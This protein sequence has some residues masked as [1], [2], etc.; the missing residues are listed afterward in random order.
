MIVPP[1]N[2]TSG[3]S[4]PALIAQP[5]ADLQP[6]RPPLPL[7]ETAAPATHVPRAAG[8]PRIP[9]LDI[10]TLRPSAP[11]AQAA[12]VAAL[13]GGHDLDAPLDATTDHAL[14]VLLGKYAQ[15]LGLIER[16]EAV[17]I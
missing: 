9:R 7:L 3:M 5:T 16:L 13:V 4:L 2:A 11:S 14:L 1:T 10:G 15:H 6:R 12:Q 8:A 17:P